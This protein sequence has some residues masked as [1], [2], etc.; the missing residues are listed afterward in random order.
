MANECFAIFKKQNF[1]ERHL[2]PEVLS[3]FDFKEELDF[4]PYPDGSQFSK[5]IT[6]KTKESL[7]DLAN[8]HDGEIRRVYF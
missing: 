4:R 3:C 2:F 8:I 1:L 7:S 5:F 6:G